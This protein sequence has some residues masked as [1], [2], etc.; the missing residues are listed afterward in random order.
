[1]MKKPGSGALE[2]MFFPG[3]LVT[4]MKALHRQADRQGRQ[5][6][7]TRGTFQ[8]MFLDGWYQDTVAASQSAVVLDRWAAVSYLRKVAF[9]RD[10]AVT[11]VQARLDAALTGGTCSVEVWINGAASGLAAA[12]SGDEPSISEGNGEVGFAAGDVIELRLT[13]SAGF[14]PTSAN[15]LC[16]VGLRFG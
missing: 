1:M 16:M 12:L 5:L 8:E 9:G 2:E 10:G 15:V 13:T 14:A 11:W 3:N 6:L 7:E 4:G